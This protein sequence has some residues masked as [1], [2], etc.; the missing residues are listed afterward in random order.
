M[1]VGFL[2][3]CGVGLAAC[4]DDQTNAAL[5][6]DELAEEM[7]GSLVTWVNEISTATNEL[8]DEVQGLLAEGSTQ[9]SPEVD[10]AF[11][12]WVDD[13][14]AAS[15]ER[16]AAVDELRFPPTERGAELADELAAAAAD[17]RAEV[18]SVRADVEQLL[19]TDE[20][21]SGRMSTILV[22]TEK[23]LSLAE[24]DI[25]GGD[26]ADELDRAI[27]AEPSCEHVTEP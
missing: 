19:A 15:D 23:V 22:N 5:P 27:L 16:V 3:T 10:A 7:C 14:E 1:L 13:V 26:D 25:D 4:A 8:D 6:P 21:M 11:V 9:M 18:D 24:P 12:G 2:L 20:T 17:A